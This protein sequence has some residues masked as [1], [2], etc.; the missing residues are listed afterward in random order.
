MDNVY[1]GW[2]GLEAG[3]ATVA[4]SVVGPLRAGVSRAATA[5]TT[6]TGPG[7]PRSAWCRRARC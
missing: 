6:G 3:M 7:S 2:D 5:A 1:D 4:A